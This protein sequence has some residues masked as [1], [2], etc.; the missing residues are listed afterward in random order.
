VSGREEFGEL[1][2]PLTLAAGSH[3]GPDEG[4][5]VVELASL[6]GGEPFSDH[7]ECVCPVIGSYLRAWN[8]RAAH[9]ARQQLLPYAQRIVG[10]RGGGDMTLARRDLCLEAAGANLSGP[11][12]RRATVRLAW[13]LRI[14]LLCGLRRGIGLDEGAAEYAARLLFARGEEAAAFELLEKMLALDMH[15]PVPVPGG[16]GA[17]ANGHSDGGN[18]SSPASASATARGSNGSST[19]TAQPAATNGGGNGTGQNGAPAR[20]G[21]PASTEPK[22]KTRR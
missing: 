1:R 2:H 4:V 5:C 18:G 6:M 19:G 12:P 9:H 20:N 10:S 7:P 13:R 16:N 15:R 11:W 22:Q 14:A 21:S 17:A 3:A 8:D